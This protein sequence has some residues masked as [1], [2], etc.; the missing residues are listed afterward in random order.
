MGFGLIFA[1]LV[2]FFN[3][4]IHIIDII[5]DFL[6]AILISVGLRKLADIEDRFYDARKYARIMIGVYALKAVLSLYVT[7]RWKDGLL[8]VTFAFSVG[9][10]L[11]SIA[12]FTAL[13]GGIEYMANRHNGE[14]HL[15]NVG[16]MLQFS[17]FFSIAKSTLAFVPE[18]FALQKDPELDLSY[19]AK[20]AFSLIDAKPYAVVLCTVA[21]LALGIWFLVLTA[22]YFRGL[23]QDKTFN[24]ELFSIYR[25]R[26]LNN[27]CRMHRRAFR[28]Y[29]LL[30]LFAIVFLLDFS[31]D[32]VPLTPHVLAYVLLYAAACGP[33]TK[34][35]RKRFLYLVP[36]CAVS[37][38]NAVYTSVCGAGVN[39]IMDYESYVSY[40][41]GM[42][43]SGSAVPIQAAL[44]LCEGILF[45][46]FAYVQTRAVSRAYTDF[47]SKPYL[48]RGSVVYPALLALASTAVR[49]TPLLKAKYYSD[50]INDTFLHADCKGLSD[51]FELAQGWSVIVLLV[52]AVGYALYTV[53]LQ[54]K[55]DAELAPPESL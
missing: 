49:V 27:P 16:G 29:F 55:A 45:V 17:I 37:L 30:T 18:A 42:V 54:R 31:V 52:L 25:E 44:S 1:G 20:P 53:N 28:H 36:L 34:E 50:Y 5:P 13:Y 8:P 32:T 21:I 3:P 43:S 7:A 40:S 2:F 11:L 15:A 46:L 6:G 23:W 22:R 14:K 19:N 41:V 9:E 24:T 39:H 35:R 10:I 33:D 12:F 48:T 4:C 26:V 51:F 47:C 38:L